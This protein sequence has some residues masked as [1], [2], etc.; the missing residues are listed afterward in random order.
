MSLAMTSYTDLLQ[1]ATRAPAK[2][3]AWLHRQWSATRSMWTRGGVPVRTVLRRTAVSSWDDDVVGE[4]AELAYWFLFATFPLLLFLMAL[5][6]YVVEGSDEL[7]RTLFRYIAQVSPSP[8]V[9]DLLRGTLEEVLERRG[10][11]KLSLGLAVALWVAS[12]GM[13]AVGKAL[14]VACNLEETRGWWR[15]R[16]SALGL[17]IVFAGLTVSA[18]VLVLYGV[19]IGEILDVRMGWGNLSATAW[20]FLH[21]PFVALFVLL[22]FEVIYNFAPNLHRGERVW[23]TPGAFVGMLLWIGASLGFRVY[24]TQFAYY[25]KTYGSLGVVIILLLWF[26]LAGIAILLGGEVNSACAAAAREKSSH[27]ED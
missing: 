6:G 7:R 13:M 1:R 2:L 9:T 24:L 25:S 22:A 21:W 14:N 10:G 26:Y 11:A 12:T 5:F 23:L 16:V 19:Q 18:L 17:T 15:Q 8:D 3:R 27:P 4:A 20:S